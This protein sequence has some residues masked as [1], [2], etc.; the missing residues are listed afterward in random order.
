MEGNP[1]AAV[2]LPIAPRKPA[3]KRA[4]HE[5][6]VFYICIAPFILGILIF[7]FLPLL[8]SFVL[9]FTKWDILTPPVFIGLQNY[10]TALTQ[11]PKVLISLQVTF[12]YAL[13]AIPLRLAVALLLAVL[14]N[15][16]TKGVGIFRTAF[17]IPSIVSSV[18]AAV[19]WMWLLN[20]QFGPVDGFLGLF[21]IPGPQ[22]FT[23]PNFALWG[24]VMM[25]PWGAGGEMLI[26]LAGLKGIDKQLYE[27]AE[28]D[29]AGTMSKF[30]RVTLPM[31][32]PT[33][34]FNL[35]MSIIGGLQSFDTAY[36]ISTARAGTLGGPANSTLFYMVYLYNR[37]F[38]GFQM[39]YASALGWILFVIIMVITL[40]VLRSSALWV[41]YEGERK[42]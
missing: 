25:A 5:T 29:G 31:L 16:A 24:L 23:D 4:R 9:S 20:P 35:V 13:V 17:Y 11:D 28:L 6:V 27:A 18:A 12:T 33:I 14:L 32:S 2:V 34:F 21:G 8:A 39:G 22:W 37:A 41:F 19:L 38:A 40:L 26:F 30:F 10:I 7:D 42:R 36:V 1:M 3:S 15:E